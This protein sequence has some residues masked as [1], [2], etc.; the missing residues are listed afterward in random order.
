MNQS[1]AWL[2]GSY[3]RLDVLQVPAFRSARAIAGVHAPRHSESVRLLPLSTDLPQELQPLADFVAGRAAPALPPLTALSL[4]LRY[5][6]SPQRYEPQ[7]TYGVHRV[8]PSARCLY[9]C[10][11]MLLARQHGTVQLY[12]YHGE[13]HALQACGERSDLAALLGEHDLALIGIAQ[14]WAM[15]DKYG[16]F[17][18]FASAL[19]AGMAQAQLNHLCAALNWSADSLEAS[20][21][22]MRQAATLCQG[23]HEA[24]LYGLRCKVDELSK[25]LSALQ[26]APGPTLLAASHSSDTLDQRFAKLKPLCQLLST[27]PSS[28]PAVPQQDNA[29]D[30]DDSPLPPPEIGLLQT[31]RRRN[32]GNDA[33]GMAPRLNS[34]PGDSLGRMLSLWRA[35]QRRRL[36]L[37]GEASLRVAVAWLDARS[38]PIGLYD[39]EAMPLR[40]CDDPHRFV[41]QLQD[42]LPYEGMRYNMAGLKLNFMLCADLVD[43]A[44]QHGEAALRRLYLAAGAQAQDFSLAAAAHGLFARPVR[45]LREQALETGYA[46]PGQLVYQVLCGLNRST[47]TSWE[48]M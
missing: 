32:S 37:P 47:N 18:P 19:E 15:A 33:T 44:E 10:R 14:F 42:S 2:L 24:V 13:H 34:L 35:L 41:E 43:A 31:M 39:G 46:L 5:L 21:T 11:L 7:N 9:P 6:A 30:H 8:V 1:E 36:A 22:S 20:E 4:L 16:E 48:L 38:A 17:A 3:R 25:A 40:H 27:P 29:A 28:E 23:D 26:P 12:H 45:M